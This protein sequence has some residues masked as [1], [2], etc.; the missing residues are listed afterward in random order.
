M[1]LLQMSVQPLS[2]LLICLSLQLAPN[3]KPPLAP[4][5]DSR[6]WCNSVVPPVQRWLLKATSSSIPGETL[7]SIHAGIWS[8]MLHIPTCM[9]HLF[10]LCSESLSF[11][12]RFAAKGNVTIGNESC[13]SV[14]SSICLL[15][16]HEE[17]GLHV[18]R[19]HKKGQQKCLGSIIKLWHTGQCVDKSND[20]F[21]HIVELK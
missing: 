21:V 8:L 2:V 13:T 12:L 15:H 18:T 6:Q 14:V 16:M 3:P 5:T 19:V 10:T 20:L 11:H 1:R 4:V 17:K 7:R 9:V